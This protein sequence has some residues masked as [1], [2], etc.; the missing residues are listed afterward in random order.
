[1]TMAG[2]YTPLEHYFRGLPQ[3]Q[4]EVTLPFAQIE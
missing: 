3:S 1:M 2:K 4:R